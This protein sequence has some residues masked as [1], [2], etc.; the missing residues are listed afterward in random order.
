MLGSYYAFPSCLFS[1]TEIMGSPKVGTIHKMLS[2][3]DLC[4][5]Q[6][7]LHKSLEIFKLHSNSTQ[8]VFPPHNFYQ[9]FIIHELSSILCTRIDNLGDGSSQSFF[10]KYMF[11]KN[12]YECKVNGILVNRFLSHLNFMSGVYVYQKRSP[13]IPQVIKSWCSLPF[14]CI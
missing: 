4:L 11:P 3:Y 9:L 8:Y 5:F 13:F 7:R 2:L 6:C 14:K 12:K 10:W 1:V